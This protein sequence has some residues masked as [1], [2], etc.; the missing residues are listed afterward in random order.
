M[1]HMTR[2]SH[3]RPLRRVAVA[4]VVCVAAAAS[5]PAVATSAKRAAVTCPFPHAKVVH[6]SSFVRVFRAGE[7]LAGCGRDHKV[8]RLA[9]D[10][11]LEDGMGSEGYAHVRV[12]GSW[13]AHEDTGYFYP[14]VQSLVVVQDLRRAGKRVPSGTIA[15]YA[16]LRLSAPERRVHLPT[17]VR[18]TDLELRD[19]GTVAWI[20]SDPASGQLA[21][22]VRDRTTTTDLATGTDIDPASLHLAGRKLSWIA[23]GMSHSATI[24]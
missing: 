17:G 13:V 22:R 14:I 21:V 24:S 7:F 1:A 11:D 9:H 6:V 2:R 12:A 5:T 19:T 18:V 3:D 8:K 15:Y 20:Q 23:A 4:V 16:G 10:G